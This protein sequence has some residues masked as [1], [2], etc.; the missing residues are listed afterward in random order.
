VAD[1]LQGLEVYGWGRDW[2]TC[3]NSS[4]WE[5]DGPP[6]PGGAFAPSDALPA[7]VVDVL[8]AGEAIDAKMLFCFCAA[9]DAQ[10]LTLVIEFFEAARWVALAAS[11]FFGLCFVS[12]CWLAC[13]ARPARDFDE[14]L[15][16]HPL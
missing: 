13:F 5:V 9:R 6:R 15:D 7:A 2:S 16:S 1:V 4:W 10:L 12:A 8:G 14:M 11:I 3:Y